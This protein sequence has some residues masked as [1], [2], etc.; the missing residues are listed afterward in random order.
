MA[1]GS[2]GLLLY[3]GRAIRRLVEKIVALP[4]TTVTG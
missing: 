1:R 2:G 4:W 3:D